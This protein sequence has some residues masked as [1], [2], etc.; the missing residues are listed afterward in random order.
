MWQNSRD[1]PNF[2]Q[3]ASMGNNLDRLQLLAQISKLKRPKSKEKSTI[4]VQIFTQ[5]PIYPE[6]VKFI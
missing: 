4:L 2:W 3:S 1:E 5:Y 6:R